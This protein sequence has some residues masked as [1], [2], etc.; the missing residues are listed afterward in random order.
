MM[1][2]NFLSNFQH[3]TSN[4]QNYVVQIMDETLD[5]FYSLDIHRVAEGDSGDIFEDIIEIAEGEVRRRRRRPHPDRISI[6]VGNICWRAVQWL[7]RSNVRLTDQKLIT[8]LWQMPR[9]NASVIFHLINEVTIGIID[10]Y[11]SL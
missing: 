4:I 5:N 6:T 2:S 9:L 1:M 7:P 8:I 10:L 11:S 3:P